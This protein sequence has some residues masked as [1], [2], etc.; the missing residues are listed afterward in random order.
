[1]TRTL[2]VTLLAGF[3]G[4]CSC[5]IPVTAS[6]GLEHGIVFA[7][8]EKK[9]VY[10]AGVRVR[11]VSRAAPT[12]RVA[13][14]WKD[15]WRIEGKDR[16]QQIR[17]GEGTRG[18]SIKLADAGLQQGRFYVFKVEARD[19]LGTPCVG[20]FD[21]VINAAGLLEHCDVGEECRRGIQ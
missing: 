19:S 2:I 1:M 10:Y 11:E 12:D 9:A 20:S 14:E 21:F 8:P 15:V 3:I 4:G 7:F 17:Y 5:A 16:V 13:Y 18:L 6:G